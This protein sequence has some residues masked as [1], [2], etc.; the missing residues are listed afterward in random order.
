MPSAWFRSRYVLGLVPVAIA[1]ALLQA[2]QA[3]AIR[4]PV[5]SA[6]PDFQ[7]PFTC[8]DTWDGSTRASHSP[9]PLAIDW[10]RDQND[11]GHVVVASQSGTVSSVV[12]LRTA[13]YGLYV[14]IDHDAAWS[15]LYAHLEAAFVVP[16]QRV[17]EGQPIA[18]LG[19]SGNTTGPHLHYEQRLN[20]DDRHG[21]FDE[22]R[23]HYNSWLGSRNCPDAPVVGDWHGT[24]RSAVGAFGRHASTAVLRERSRSGQVTKVPFGMPTDQPAVG[25]W[26]GNG[27]TDPG[28]WRTTKRLFVLED[29]THGRQSFHFGRRGDIAV[30]GDWNGD[31]IS[32][33]GVFD[34]ATATFRLRDGSGHVTRQRFGTTSSIPIA[35]DWDGDGRSQVGVYDPVTSTFSLWMPAGATRTITF[36][37]PFSLPVVGSWNKDDRSDIGVWDPATGLFSKRLGAH[38]TLTIRFGHRR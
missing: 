33:V 29:A 35:G 26:D 23:F 38:K 4:A 13:S 2:P 24:G 32:D 1:A 22:T 8:G 6:R 20:T 12:N 17:D 34:P 36:G 9:S 27:T 31:G 5:A 10:T 3:V 18:L 7:M 19:S 14:V 16:G 30:V 21:V 28:V 15:T 11:L 25:D 37:A